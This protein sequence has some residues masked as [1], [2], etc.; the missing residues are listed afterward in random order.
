[1]KRRVDVLVCAA[2]LLDIL[3]LPTVIMDFKGRWSGLE[4]EL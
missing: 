2:M 3:K 4:T 1:M